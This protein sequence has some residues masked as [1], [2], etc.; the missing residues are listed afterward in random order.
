MPSIIMCCTLENRIPHFVEL[1]VVRLRRSVAGGAA[2][3]DFVHRG[4][5]HG[6]GGSV[7]ALQG[8]IGDV[9]QSL[10]RSPLFLRSRILRS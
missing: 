2:R 9:A 8:Q 1:D 10:P 6:A 3:I 7:V 4:L 5:A